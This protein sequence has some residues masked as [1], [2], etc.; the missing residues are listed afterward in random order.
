MAPPSATGISITVYGCYVETLT[1][2]GVLGL[3]KARSEGA[4]VHE[5]VDCIAPACRFTNHE[6]GERHSIPSD[7]ED[8]AL[9]PGSGRRPKEIVTG[10]VLAITLCGGVNVEL[11]R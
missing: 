1:P 7:L 8:G 10:G 5:A 6:F 3:T 11:S 9:G 2:T 4:S